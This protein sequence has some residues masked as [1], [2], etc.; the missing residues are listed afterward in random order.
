MIKRGS[1]AISVALI[2]VV[3]IVSICI[4]IACVLNF[5]TPLILQQKLQSFANKYMYV[6]EKYGYLT[7]A[8][9]AL[10]V[11][12]LSAEGFDISRISVN[13]PYSKRPYGEI[14][15]FSISYSYNPIPVL[16]MGQRTVKVY[17]ASYSKI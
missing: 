11:D 4:F 6:V 5:I 17:K 13:C 16:G 10:M 15:E 2:T 12:E 7:A 8:E 14:V 9:K 3:G 1:T